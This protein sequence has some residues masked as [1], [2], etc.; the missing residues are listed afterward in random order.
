[1][2]LS[3]YL[4]KMPREENFGIILRVCVAYERNAFKE[5]FWL[6]LKLDTESQYERPGQ[7]DC[8]TCS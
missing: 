3:P 8:L 4:E 2:Q 6:G 7:A 1:M 5:G